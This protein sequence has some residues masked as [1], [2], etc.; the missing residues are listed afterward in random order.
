M[1]KLCKWTRFPQNCFLPKDKGSV[2]YLTGCGETIDFGKS[3]KPYNPI[4][5]Y[6]YDFCYRCGR[7]M[8]NKAAAK[9]R[10]GQYV[11]PTGRSTKRG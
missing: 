10:N 7:P 5:E 2:R 8:N 11:R 1:E 3:K 6:S 4:R 9:L